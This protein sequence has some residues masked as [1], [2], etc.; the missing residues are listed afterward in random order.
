MTATDTAKKSMPMT[1]KLAIGQQDWWI[2][3]VDA[4]DVIESV[5]DAM[6]NGTRVELRLYN[7][8]GHAVTVFL[9]GTT[10]PSVVLDLHM[11]PRPSEMS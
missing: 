11:G 3:D 8:A 9:N 5:R 6:T 7:A 2:A 4:N 1:K 10:A